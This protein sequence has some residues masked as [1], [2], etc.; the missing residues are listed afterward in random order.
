MLSRL[1]DPPD[2]YTLEWFLSL[3]LSGGHNLCTEQAASSVSHHSF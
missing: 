3:G 1:F 2:L